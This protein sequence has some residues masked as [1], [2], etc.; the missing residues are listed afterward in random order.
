MLSFGTIDNQSYRLLISGRGL[1]TGVRVGK[2]LPTPSLIPT[3]ATMTDS[4]SGF[5]TDSVALIGYVSLV[6]GMCVVD[7][8]FSNVFF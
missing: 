1:R 8:L 3:G 7:Y 5:D 4:N 6:F 2:I